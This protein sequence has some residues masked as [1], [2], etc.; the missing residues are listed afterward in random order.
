[1]KVP[2]LL[3]TA[4]EPAGIGPDIIIQ[5]AQEQWPAEL[6]V[7]GDPELL[8]ERSKQL[9]LP[10]NLVPFNDELSPEIHSPAQLKIIP[11][12]LQTSCIP[13]QLDITNAAYVMETL[14]IAAQQAF[15]K[16]YPIVTAPVH[17]AVLN[18]AGFAFS[19][20]TEFFAAQ[21]DL[22]QVVMLFVVRHNNAKIALVTTHLPLAKVPAAITKT[23]IMAIAHI[24]SKGLTDLFKIQ[25]PKILVCGLNPHAGENGHLGHEEID[26]IAPALTQLQQEGLLVEGPFPAD[27]VFTEKHLT[28]ADAILAMYH[29]Q[30]LPVVKAI[31]FG[32]AVNVTLGLPYIRTSV[33]HG[34]ALDVAGTNKADPS[35]LIEAAWLAIELFESANY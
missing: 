27:T 23:R 6:V 3:I 30:A 16:G 15:I 9:N 4:G 32:K 25:Q 24:L 29:D 10:L 13:G 12:S 33:D 7:I 20:H 1:M 31:G 18:E 21:Q 22:S 34:T 5:A 2:R 17:K 26:V 8:L 28:Q 11:V 35:S 14:K 19:G